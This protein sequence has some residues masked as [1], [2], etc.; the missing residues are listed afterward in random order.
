[1]VKK[2]RN[3]LELSVIRLIYQCNLFNMKVHHFGIA[4]NNILKSKG[5]YEK[6]GFKVTKELVTDYGRN[7]DYI[8]LENSG[9]LIE[10]IAKHN[11]EK[12]CDI[13]MILEQKKVIGNQVYHI[14]YES[15]ELESDIENLKREGYKLIKPPSTAIA[16][17]FKRVVFLIH[18]NLGI[19]ELIEI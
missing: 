3:S 17:D 6:L 4:C 9:V 8:F 2:T 11:H 18:F 16:A 13:D 1:M 10:L 12:K 5:Q 19:V 7:L 14:C 15:S